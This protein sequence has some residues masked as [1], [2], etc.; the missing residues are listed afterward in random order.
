MAAS[1]SCIVFG[2]IGYLFAVVVR[3]RLVLVS[4]VFQYKIQDFTC[5]DGIR[6]YQ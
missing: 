6:V 2:F 1:C 3:I 5:L 4:G